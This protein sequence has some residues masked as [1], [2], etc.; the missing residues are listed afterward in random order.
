MWT[1]AGFVPDLNLLSLLLAHTDPKSIRSGEVPMSLDIWAAATLRAAGLRGVVPLASEPF[2]VGRTAADAQTTFDVIDEDLA[3]VRELLQILRA[4]R[5]RSTSVSELNTRVR[6]L[7]GAL[8][9]LRKDME[10]RAEAV[11]GEGRKKQTDVFLAE[12]D[13]GLELL[14]STKSIAVA[15]DKEGELS[16]NLANRWEEFDGDLKNLRGRFPMAVIGALVLLPAS[17]VRMN[18]L[19]AFV[20]MMTKITAPGRPWV[21]AYDAACIVIG[22]LDA[23]NESRVPL[24][25]DELDEAQLPP[26]LRPQAFF[27][28]L[29]QRLFERAPISEHR[30]ARAAAEEGRGGDPERL[31]RAAEIESDAEHS[32]DK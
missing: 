12:W 32:D 9:I 26:S 7:T 27:D 24:L 17:V 21:N 25:G 3:K 20:D 23:K 29:L 22:D 13:R 1:T 6:S 19:A 5:P 18:L 8:K 2:Y 16:K 30:E 15:V 10:R 28:V 31:L 4:D 14:I 11:L